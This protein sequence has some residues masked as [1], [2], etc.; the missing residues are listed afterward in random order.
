MKWYESV[1]AKLIG[2][3][4]LVSILFLV[5]IVSAFSVVKEG[6]VTENAI[7]E[8]TSASAGIIEEIKTTQLKMEES[9]IILA[10]ITKDQCENTIV[11]VNMVRDLLSAINDEHI[12]SG[13]VWFEPYAIDNA[14]ANNLLFF[15]RDSNGRFSR[16]L[17]YAG[18]IPTDYRK[19]EFYVLGKSLKSG[20]AF[21]TKVYKDPVTQIDMMTIVSPIYRG[22]TFLGVASID[23]QI[24]HYGKKM[25]LPDQ[26]YLVI[27]DRAGT[28]IFKSKRVDK[29]V[30]EDNIYKMKPNKSVAAVLR[31]IKNILKQ[32]K[33][34]LR[35]DT[36]LASKLD[37]ASPY[38]DKADAREISSL[39]HQKKNT[40][41]TEVHFMEDDPILKEDSILAVFY[42]PDTD[43]TLVVGLSEKKILAKFNYIYLIII[44]IT[45]IMT[46]I[47]TLIGYFVLKRYF[48][49]PIESI[50]EQL[51]NSIQEDGHYRFL[52]C[53]DKG[54]IGQ[55]VYN[56]NSRTLALED[57]Q[58]R[59]KEEIQKR[60][61][62]EKLLIQQSKMAAMGE[63]M[64]AVAHQWKQPLNALSMYSEII[65]LD[66]E[67]GMVDQKYV[68]EFR[69]NLQVQ[70]G[71]MIDTLDEF[72]TFFRPN[73]EHE[74]F[75]VSEVIAS[76]LFLTKDEFLKN[77]ITVTVEKEKEITLH[78]S[79]NEFKHLILNLLNN[80]KDAFND[81]HIEEK[82]TIVI[83]L[84]E[85][86][87]GK[88][89]E[90]EDNA[91]GI[92]EDVLPDIFKANVTTKEEG[93]GTGIGLY[94][95]MQIAEKYD[96]EL[97]AENVKGGA[98][99]TLL[100]TKR[101]AI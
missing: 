2:F 63:M 26:G 86:E 3:F 94:M 89:I 10:S 74:D 87:R 34:T 35:Y 15:N 69:D 24:G 19:M 100:F 9:V 57:A 47:A 12:V 73:K 70:I 45:V 65:R 28:F 81:N 64:D 60:V 30:K 44:I 41:L 7:Q 1:K 66:F 6:R 80:A 14:K 32:Q 8:A 29:Y 21:W 33:N 95:S 88:R 13:G 22:K 54:E 92:P 37:K 16:L 40:M 75:T 79:R 58:R 4:V 23:M 27:L 93:K 43:W 59:E 5:F 76:V 42:F 72:R 71:H 101:S 39:L 20:E 11:S 90:V 61:T 51:Q 55:L 78:G 83:R 62:N 17:N 91:G 46:I 97:S 25:K 98:R 85:D 18:K 52:E 99:F 53:Q 31:Y 96:A 84:L 67:E 49:H 48:V 56:L 82:R 50:N 68:D 77:R 36:S 38:I